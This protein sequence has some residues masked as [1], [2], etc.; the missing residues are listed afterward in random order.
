M[1]IKLI[2]A[3]FI[4][5]NTSAFSQIMCSG[6]SIIPIQTYNICDSRPWQLVFED[7]FDEGY[8]DKTK[9]L[10]PFQGVARDFAF[11]NEKQWYANPG[12][13][14]TI[15]IS[16]NLLV[17]NSLLKFIARKE[18]PA[19]SGTYIVNWSPLTFNSST[20][21]YSSA[22]VETPF[23]FTYGYCEIRCKIPSG[24]GFWPAFWMYGENDATSVNNDIDVFEFWNNQS[25]E[26]NMTVHYNGGM[27]GPTSFNGVDYSQDFH[28]YGVAWENDRIQWYV[29]G[30]LK[31]TDYRYVFI[32][33]SL[34]G[35]TLNA[36][37][38]YLM[39]KVYPVDPMRIIIDLAIQSNSAAPDGST[40]F[41]SEMLI[42]WVKFFKREDCSLSKIITNSSQLILTQKE[43]NSV[44]G[45][46]VE[47]N[48]SYTIPSNRQLEII[49]GA[50]IV[51]KPGFSS[52]IG[53]VC[54]A[55]ISDDVCQNFGKASNE[56]DTGVTDH[57]VKSLENNSITLDQIQ[58]FPNPVSGEKININFGDLKPS[59]YTLRVFDQQGKVVLSHQGFEGDSDY[60]DL[61]NFE[62]GLYIFSFLNLSSRE[63]T[64]FNIIKD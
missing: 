28:T 48:T 16:N 29:D 23:R 36:Y 13:S 27:C 54:K 41:P 46:T 38:Q 25:D 35:C 10:L 18:N 17:E 21:D 14:P 44:L 12:T 52:V 57:Q 1:K 19:I 62:K 56:D 32:N 9:W 49:G 24:K 8:L 3:W 31:R 59:E 30:V 64:N 50:D 6:Q 47:F 7:Y 42:D 5:L 45:Q 63:L 55:R 34:I 4:L 61:S 22:Q 53:S 37:Q 51:L 11:N 40:V 60:V 15:P 33:G 39:N 2:I 58:L 43:Y 26:P 20:F